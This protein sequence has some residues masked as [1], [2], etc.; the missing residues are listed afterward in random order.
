M[1]LTRH[2]KA[3]NCANSG[4]FGRTTLQANI[5][6]T[7][8]KTQVA[9]QSKEEGKR[10]IRNRLC[11]SNVLILLDDVDDRKQLEALVG[12]H[13]WF[14]DGSHIIITS[15]NE[16]QLQKVDYVSHVRCNECYDNEDELQSFRHKAR[17]QDKV[18]DKREESCWILHLCTGIFYLKG[19]ERVMNK[20][21]DGAAIFAS[22]YWLR[23]SDMY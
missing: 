2:N 1:A 22:S 5:L 11:R 14:G 21:P 3:K 7:L 18:Y 9:V 16:H 8:L 6:S 19:H 4:W 17:Q 20:V 13:K 10:M 15:R 12:S 23:N